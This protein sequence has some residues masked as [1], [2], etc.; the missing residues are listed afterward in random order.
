MLKDNLIL[1]RKIE[2]LQ[3]L[4]CDVDGVLTDGQLHYIDT[5]IFYKSF[6]VHDGLGL[7]LL[8][9]AGIEVAIITACHSPHTQRRMEDLGIKWVFKGKA[10]KLTSYQ[11][12][13]SH[14][15]LKDEEIGYV[16]DDIADLP[17]LNQVGIK[18]TVAN[19]NHIIQEVA[20]YIASKNG[21]CGA[22]R[23]ICDLILTVRGLHK[24]AIDNYLTPAK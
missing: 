7:Q 10:H 5:G 14:L 2:K 15:S 8:K 19:A 23:E 24:T 9:N 16:G 12:L 6:H 1:Q 4:I 18:F 11:E 20:D 17:V 21:G 22:V 13:K 3:L